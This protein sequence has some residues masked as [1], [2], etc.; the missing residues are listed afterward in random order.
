MSSRI[1]VVSGLPRS[2]TSL[3]MQMLVAG[4]VSA[5]TDERRPSDTNNPRG[6]WEYE[7]V[8]SI[9]K[10]N[11]WM[12][13][14]KG[15]AI[16]I[17]AP[18]ISFVPNTMEYDILFVRR[19]LSEVIASQA[20]MLGR[21]GKQLHEQHDIAMAMKQLLENSIQY[22]ET[23][24]NMRVAV[25]EHQQLILH[26]AVAIEQIQALLDSPLDKR[27][28]IEAVDPTLYRNRKTGFLA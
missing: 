8:K 7:A 6:Y 24:P 27:A 9:A 11:G 1:I 5:L 10:E 23:Q 20:R 22:A 25:L 2:G 17:I 3:V 13:L 12:H 21:D 16:K 4:G 18:L 28:M 14:A 15:K 19:D 26:P